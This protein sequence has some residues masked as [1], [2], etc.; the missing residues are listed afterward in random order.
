MAELESRILK[1]EEAP[2]TIE[3]DDKNGF[4][5]NQIAN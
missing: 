3:F 1:G 5:S 4:V 2:I